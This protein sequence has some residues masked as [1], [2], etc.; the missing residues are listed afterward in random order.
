MD[1]ATRSMGVG[2][3]YFAL[4]AE[5]QVDAGVR[6]GLQRP[7]AGRAGGRDDGGHRGAAARSAA[8]TRSPCA[9]RSPRPAGRRR[10]GSPRSS[11]AGVRA[12]FQ[13]AIEAVVEAGRADASLAA[14]TRGDI[15]NYVSA[16]FSST[17]C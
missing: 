13:D 8:T 3:A 7:L 17:S 10:A 1:V 16:L 12:A 9:A 14:V 2:P 4:V 15:A 11:A 6:H 5:A